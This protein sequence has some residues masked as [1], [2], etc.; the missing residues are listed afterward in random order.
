MVSDC[1][2]SVVIATCRREV[3]LLEAIESAL[4]ERSLRLEVIIIDDSGDQSAKPAVERIGDPRVR[5]I[6][7]HENSGRRPGL[8]RNQ[9]ARVARGKFLY[10]LDDDDR[11]V[12]GALGV[13]VGALDSNADAG[14]VFGRVVPFSDDPDVLAHE[15]AFFE[16]AAVRAARLRNSRRRFAA[17]LL[18]D[19]TCLVNSACMVRR[20][21]FEE[22]GGYDTEL[23]VIE[24]IELFLRA[25]RASGVVFVDQPVLHYRKGH[26]SLTTDS[27]N[28]SRATVDAAYRR[29]HRK[30]RGAFG[31]PEFYAL[32]MA[33]RG[34]AKISSVLR[35]DGKAAKTA[36]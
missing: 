13:L 23:T 33:A 30:Y 24:D 6:G 27:T 11:V 18:F 2:V 36:S 1:D 32:K 21:V 3:F 35:R 14:V 16:R 34:L 29:M 15:R 25:G 22:V 8:V 17:L 7:R 20:D 12:A 5:Y 10:F 28:T 4:A 9:G 19:D 31:T 26:A